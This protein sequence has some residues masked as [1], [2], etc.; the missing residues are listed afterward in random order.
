[1]RMRK[2]VAPCVRDAVR[3]I[4]CVVAGLEISYGTLFSSDRQEEEKIMCGISALRTIAILTGIANPWRSVITRFRSFQ[5]GGFMICSFP[6]TIHRST[7]S[8]IRTLLWLTV[9][10]VI[11]HRNSCI[12]S[13]TWSR[14]RRSCKN[15]YWKSASS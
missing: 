3:L 10:V 14:T 4:F 9:T 1:M 2:I 13:R 15:S 5:V 8:N 11:Y 7:S 6:S 12:Q